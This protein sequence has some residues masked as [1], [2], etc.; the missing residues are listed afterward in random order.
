MKMAGRKKKVDW[1]SNCGYHLPVT[2]HDKLQ[3]SLIALLLG[4]RGG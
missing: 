2:M 3:L 4:L 1:P